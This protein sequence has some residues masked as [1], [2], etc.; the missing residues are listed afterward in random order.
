MSGNTN[1]S[2]NDDPT[3]GTSDYSST[4]PST[5]GSND[6]SGTDS[7]SGTPGFGAYSASE[8]TVTTTTVTRT[9]VFGVGGTDPSTDDTSS[10]S[11]GTHDPAYSS[12]DSY[13]SA[14]ST[15]DTSGT[16]S[17]GYVPVDLDGDGSADTVVPMG[18]DASGYSAGDY[19]SDGQGPTGT[20]VA[21]EHYEFETTSHY[22]YTAAYADGSSFDTPETDPSSHYGSG[23]TD[24]YSDLH[25]G[26]GQY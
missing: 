11:Y 25:Q 1:S 16:S 24:D 21:V 9:S 5:T 13:P 23:D 18:D 12:S 20:G 4:Y 10:S 26:H 17:H 22:D 8:T 6:Y 2:T 3:T 7:H 14:S 15:H 19:G